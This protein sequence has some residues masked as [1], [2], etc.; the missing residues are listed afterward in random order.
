MW[1]F[2][3]FTLSLLLAGL[4]VVLWISEWIPVYLTALLPL[5]FAVPLGLLTPK[6][7]AQCYGDSNIFLFFGGFVMALAL[8]K[9]G[10]HEQIARR[11]IAIVG[12][13]K[14]NILLGFILSTGLISM[15]ISNTATALMMLPM[16]I[17]V[18]EAMPP[19][20]RQSRFSVFLM[21]SIAYAS[22]IGGV[23]TLI[24]SPPN[25]QMASIL[26][27][28]FQVEIS[29]FDWM[30]IGMPLAIILLLLMF[31]IFNYMLGAERKDVHDLHFHTLPWTK[32]QKRVLWIFSIVAFLWIFREVFVGFG[33]NYRDEN[34]AILGALAMFLVPSGESAKDKILRWTDTEKLP[35][36]I[37]LLFGGGL[38]LAAVLEKNGV[39]KFLAAT[40]ESFNGIG[41]VAAILILTA[42]AIFVSEVLSN[43]AMVTL[44]VPVVGI[45]ANQTGLPLVP[46]AM[47]LT[48]GASLA[49]MMPVGTP[50][51]AIVF[52]S[53]YLRIKDMIRFGFILN[54]I[55]LA[56]ISLFVIL[57][58]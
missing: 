47:A 54:L 8:E 3:G 13:K 50:P 14:S 16:A 43:L 56:L 57:F 37:L 24:G 35:W 32:A 4:M 52:G 18:I 26:A 44:F 20:H 22:N 33:I 6:D 5:L 10:V 19:A 48:L 49:F 41:L 55:S 31:L 40:F 17:A 27:E 29:F 23:G 7:L 34:A 46:L 30:K 45:F 39:L 25:T 21:L 28:N 42:L 15:W 9:W 58:L 12:D 36:G 2:D 11:I 1:V 38:A 53:G 51:N